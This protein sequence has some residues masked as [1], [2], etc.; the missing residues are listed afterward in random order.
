[1]CIRLQINKHVCLSSHVYFLLFVI[2]SYLEIV[3]DIV[4]I[5]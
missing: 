1:M 2:F 5:V 4:F 3:V